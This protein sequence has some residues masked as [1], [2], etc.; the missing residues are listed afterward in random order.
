[1]DQSIPERDDLDFLFDFLS[2]ERDGGPIFMIRFPGPRDRE[3]TFCLNN[4]E[5]RKIG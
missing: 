4:E 3:A 1:M 2:A 5:G